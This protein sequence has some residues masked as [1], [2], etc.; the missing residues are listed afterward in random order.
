MGEFSLNLRQHR[1][2]KQWRFHQDECRLATSNINSLWKF[3]R[4]FRNGICSLPKMCEIQS[5]FDG[6]TKIQAL[7]WSSSPVNSVHSPEGAAVFI[8]WPLLLDHRHD[9]RALYLNCVPCSGHQLPC[10][11]ESVSYLF[12]VLW[13]DLYSLLTLEILSFRNL[14]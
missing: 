6:T 10:C 1:C 7:S 14:I 9:H 3:Y 8:T 13:K 11:A 12:T 5:H 2:S 4:W